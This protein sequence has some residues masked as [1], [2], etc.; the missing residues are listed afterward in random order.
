MGSDPGAHPRGRWGRMPGFRNRK[1][2]YFRNG[3]YPLARLV[4]VDF[5]R[6][7]YIPVP[8]SSPDPFP[9][10]FA[11]DSSGAVLPTPVSDRF[12]IVSGGGCVSSECRRA[13]YDCGDQH[14]TDFR[15]C[16]ALMRRGLSDSE[17]S[18]RLVS[19]RADWENHK[20]DRRMGDYLKR[21]IR[22]ARLICR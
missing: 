13:D 21:T 14:R 3:E 15:F 16:L 11:S 5:R 17:I 10:P 2:K 9:V 22:R 19:E 6:A 7:A 18:G 12:C 4:W 20:G 8:E 1:E